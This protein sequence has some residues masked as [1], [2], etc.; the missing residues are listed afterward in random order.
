[1]FREI[2]L[3]YDLQGVPL[4]KSQKEMAVAQKLGIFD[5]MIIKPKC[6]FVKLKSSQFSYLFTIFSVSIFYSTFPI[7]NYGNVFCLY[8]ITYE[9]EYAS[10]V[11]IYYHRSSG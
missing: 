5:P 10:P 9:N 2:I 1:M 4:E 6:F 7:A 8:G 3:I 11:Q